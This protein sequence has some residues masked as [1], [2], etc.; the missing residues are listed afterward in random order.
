MLSVI[1]CGGQTAGPGPDSGVDSSG[2]PIILPSPADVCDGVSTLTGDHVLAILQPYY[3]ATYSPMAGSPSPLELFIST[4]SNATITCHPHVV[5][6]GGPPDMAASISVAVQ[7]VFA[8]QDKT[9]NETFTATVTLS[10]V[11][12]SVALAFAGTE[13]VTAIQGTFQPAIAG[14]WT[15]HDLSFSGELVPSTGTDGGVGTTTGS[16]TEQAN[17]GNMG[18]VRGA[19]SWK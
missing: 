13:P 5:S 7:A 9:F 17:N 4:T 14:T 6:N 12:S 10:A 1:A 16:V 2:G 11:Q 19:G 15:T 3:G 8:T 18:M